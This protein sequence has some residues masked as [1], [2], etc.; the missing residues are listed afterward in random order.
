MSNLDGP[1]YAA[2]IAH[3][4]DEPHAVYIVWDGDVALYVGMTSDWWARTGQHMRYF[5]GTRYCNATHIDVWECADSR[6]EAEVIERD[7]IRALDPRENTRHS[8]SREAE[9]A[10][11][12]AEWI[13]Q[14]NAYRVR[15]GM[16]PI[17]YS[18]D[19]W[20][21]AQPQ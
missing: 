9:Y 15:L 20:L 14:D 7:V 11:A 19:A 12:R 10:R 17:D 16:A 21:Q 5:D 18:V 2:A 4:A 8:P 3:L 1:R 6:Y 13:E